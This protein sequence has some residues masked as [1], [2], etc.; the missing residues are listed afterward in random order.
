MLVHCALLGAIIVTR[1]MR[2]SYVTYLVLHTQSSY[3]RRSV[4]TAAALVLYVHE[5]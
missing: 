4:A 2:T 3:S 1:L 5:P